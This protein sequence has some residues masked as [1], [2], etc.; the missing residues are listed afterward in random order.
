MKLKKPISPDALLKELRAIASDLHRAGQSDMLNH[1]Q[2]CL[3]TAK[4]IRSWLRKVQ[5][6]PRIIVELE[7]GLVAAVWTDLPGAN[8]SVLDPDA[9]ANKTEDEE[10]E[11]EALNRE[12]VND[13]LQNLR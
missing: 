11:D 9:N 10:R 5:L 12:I 6:T 1:D 3:D 2:V 8:V 4:S 7:G 13:K